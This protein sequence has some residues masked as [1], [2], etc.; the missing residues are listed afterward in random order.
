MCSFSHK[1]R[2]L[3]YR[4][5]ANSVVSQCLSGL[6]TW[7]TQ[8]PTRRS[9]PPSSRTLRLDYLT[10][11]RRWPRLELSNFSGGDT[12][13]TRKRS[14]SRWNTLFNQQVQSEWSWPLWWRFYCAIFHWLTRSQNTR[15]KSSSP[16]FFIYF[17]QILPFHYVFVWTIND[18]SSQPRLH[19]MLR[20]WSSGGLGDSD[21]PVLSSS[22]QMLPS[23][24]KGYSEGK[25]LF[26]V[27][28]F[29]VILR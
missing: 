14:S 12:A 22:T 28:V 16:V 5:L 2:L 24:C 15:S 9:L 3:I 23:Y 20:S 21:M 7:A 27:K 19:L 8:S 10:F 25:S 13:P 4:R 1:I 6:R 29:I 17:A 11:R 18:T 26:V